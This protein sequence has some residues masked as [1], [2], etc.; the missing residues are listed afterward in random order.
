MLDEMIR[1]KKRGIA[2]KV[3]VPG[4]HNDHALTRSSGRSAYG[5]LLKAGAEIY[6]YETSMIHAKI[7]IIDGVWSVVGSTNLDNRSFGINDEVNLAI[8]DSA[9]AEKL[10]RDFEGDAAQ[11]K[12]VTLDEWENRSV[13]ERVLEWIGWILERQQ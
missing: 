8:L 1:A 11:S 2:V 12:R 13:F 4:K 6:E 5:G 10:T 3:I 7:A 9:V